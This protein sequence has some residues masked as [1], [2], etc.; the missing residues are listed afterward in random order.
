MD[1][2]QFLLGL[3]LIL[4]STKALGLLTRKFKMPQVVGALLA[5]LL[6][7]PAVFNLMS[8]TDFIEKV[9]EIGVIVLMFGA[10][11]E[12]DLQELKK[13]GGPAFIIAM[14]GVIVPVI[15]GFAVASIFHPAAGPEQRLLVLQNIFIGVILSA[16]SVSITV[17]TLKELGKLT[18]KSGNAILGAAIID[19]IIGIVA[20]TLITSMADTSIRI[21]TIVFQLIGFFAFSGIAGYLFFRFYKKWTD[22]YGS[23]LRRFII[24]AFTFC[25]V[26]S[27]CAD[28]FFGVAD[29]TGA[30]IAG[31]IISC[32]KVKEYVAK[33][34][35][36]LSYM[37]FSPVFFASIGLKVSVPE[38]SGSVLFFTISL[39]IVAVLSKVVG[40]GIG[41][42]LCK[43]DNHDA[44]CIGC[45]M[46][47][48]GEVALIV[49]NKG[50]SMGL[51]SPELFAPVV[52]IVMFTSIISPILLKMAYAHH[53]PTPGDV[54]QEDAIT[55]SINHQLELNQGI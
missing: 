48:R 22:S 35:D 27:Y 6:L 45:G 55:R 31:L 49:A 53:T 50:A 29:I 2:L 19:D 21:S 14:M 10:G 44:V 40:C 11:V 4:F 30:Y 25:L 1:S 47:S 38:F 33:R 13:S 46:I 16:T 52:L 8:A 7:G 34:F 24:I 3:A 15:G 54:F 28:R 26:M 42:K 37:M 17:E 36:T 51:M 23:D 5:G 41:A 43:Y 18:T 12:T 20:L 39:I 32:T 9:A